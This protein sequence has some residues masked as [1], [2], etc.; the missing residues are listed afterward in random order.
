MLIG[1]QTLQIGKLISMV[2]DTSTLSF[3]P[4]AFSYSGN[5]DHKLVPSRSDEIM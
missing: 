3:P 5:I 2:K 1:G 4:L